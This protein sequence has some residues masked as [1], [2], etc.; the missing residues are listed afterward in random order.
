MT[1]NFKYHVIQSV[2]DIFSL[3]GKKMIELAKEN[4]RIPAKD[5]W[6]LPAFIPLMPIVGVNN[7]LTILDLSKIMV[8]IY[9]IEKT[10]HK[11]AIGYM[12]NP[13]FILTVYSENRFKMLGLLFFYQDNEKY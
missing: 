11:F 3:C 12:I 7:C 10:I 13:I 4:E 1:M 5:K 8:H 2:I 6:G 9:S